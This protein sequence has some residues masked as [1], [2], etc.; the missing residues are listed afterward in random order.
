MTKVLEIPAD[1]RQKERG[2]NMNE[3]P[4]EF[5]ELLMRVKELISSDSSADQAV[6]VLTFKGS[7]LYF[8][9]HNVMSGS[10]E[11]EIVFC[12]TLTESGDTQ[13]TH[14]VCMWNDFTLDI[15]SRHLRDLLVEL[16]PS[17]LETEI[18][19]IGGEEFQVKL[20]KELTPQ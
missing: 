8:A 2:K 4:V 5:E 19:L 11:D 7:L 13:I 10:V 12:K 14:A 15:P 3:I 18:L 16:D 20:W 6:A 17:N 1:G 9:N